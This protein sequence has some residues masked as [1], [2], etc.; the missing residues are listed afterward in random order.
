L[1]FV[2]RPDHVEVEHRDMLSTGTGA[3][4]TNTASRAGRA[5][6]RWKATKSDGAPRG[7]AASSRASSITAAVPEALSSAPLRMAWP[8]R[9]SVAKVESRPRWSKCAPST[10]T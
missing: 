3:C 9:T 6:R 8:A 10:T 1:S 5:P 2:S 4:S 7:R